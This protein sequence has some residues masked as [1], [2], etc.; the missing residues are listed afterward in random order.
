M[1]RFRL[2]L[3]SL[4][5]VLVFSASALAVDVKVS[6]EY[7]VGGM[8]LNKT[9]V[10]DSDTN[11]STAFFYQRL[12]VKTDFVV[13]P[14]LKLVTRFDAMERI[15]GGTRN[16]EAD[17][18]ALASDSSGSRAENENIAFDWAYLEYKSPIG[19]FRAGIM[20]KGTTGTAFGNSIQ[21]SPRI[22]Y[23]Y[24]KGPWTIDTTYSMLKE[25]SSSAI[26]AVSYTDADNDEFTI[27]PIYKWKDGR[28]GIGI[29]YIRQAEKRPS[30]DYKK[31]YFQFVPY[32]IAKVGPVK[33]EAE[34]GYVTGKERAYDDG[35]GD[36]KLENISAYVN[37]SSDFGMFYAGAIMAYVSGDKPETTDKREGGTLT[38]GR[39]WQPALIMWNYERTNWAGALPGHNNAAQ[40]T[41]MANGYFYQIRG[42]VKPTSDL[43]IMASLSYATADKKPAGF[44]NSE[45]GYEVDLIANYNITNNLSYML[46]FG[47]LFTG[48]YY[49]GKGASN[50]INDDYLIINK[51]TL[52]F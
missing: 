39:D 3:L 32:A 8:Y 5:M 40:D 15:W 37:A 4:G 28:A 6:G 45:Y 10:D 22:K 31:T 41:R 42:G 20:N 50:E 34:A 13:S 16:T 18:P 51:L 19:E 38:G 36:I 23:I 27:E 14:G 25:G 7:F 35:I 24:T 52:T 21:P 49:K 9:R 46:G 2:M 26:Q 29:S 12:R 44:L 48:D 47:Y 33:V 43:D 17:T 1:K 30:D 11:P